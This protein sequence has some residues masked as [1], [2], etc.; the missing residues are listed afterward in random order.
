MKKVIK[1]PLTTTTGEKAD[2]YITV[3]MVGELEGCKIKRIENPIIMPDDF[4]LPTAE[5]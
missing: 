5:G 1:I 3:D 2:V 4:I